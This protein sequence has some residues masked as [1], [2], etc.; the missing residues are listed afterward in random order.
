M[1]GKRS[2][3]IV[4]GVTVLMVVVLLVSGCAKAP[5]EFEVTE[6]NIPILNPLTGGFASWGIELK[7]AMD[8]GVKDVNA[9]GGVAGKPL[10]FT[11]YD[12]GSEASKSRSVTA[13]VLD[14]KPLIIVQTDLGGSYAATM[15]LTV[16]EQVFVIGPAPG[17]PTIVEYIPWNMSFLNYSETWG[18]AGVSEW[19]EA[20]PDIERVVVFHDTTAEVYEIKADIISEAV[21]EAGRVAAGKVGFEQFVTVDFGSVALAGLAQ[22]ADGFVFGCIGNASAKLIRELQK[23]GVTENRRFLVFADSD[24]PDFFEIGEG[25]IDGIYMQSLYDI[26]HPSERWQSIKSRFEAYSPE[27]PM[28]IGVFYGYDTVLFIKAA[29]AE[30]GVTGD[31][32]KL[33]EE[34]LMLAHWCYNQEDFPFVMGPSDV[35]DGTT[36]QPIWLNRIVNNQKV[37]FLKIL[38]E[39]VPE[40]YREAPQ[41]PPLP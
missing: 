14:T 20:E 26:N 25:R 31:P 41:L 2:K 5:P 1:K 29:I 9:A 16:P 17:S 30:T 8:E 13:R 38:L 37:S 19:L 24:Y 21:E 11:Y 22:N 35:V 36:L 6:W 32:A 34:R 23:R 3:L 28:G 18:K 27:T 4:L 12:T 39:E 10:S 7:W 15:G 33:A 40:A